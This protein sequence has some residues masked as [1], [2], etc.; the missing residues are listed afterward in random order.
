VNPV[1][2]SSGALAA[3]SRRRSG[4]NPALRGGAPY[5]AEPGNILKSNPAI[6]GTEE[7]RPIIVSLGEK[8]PRLQ[9]KTLVCTLCAGFLDFPS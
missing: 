9:A 7:Q 4:L 3:L 8:N 6:S 2:N 1:R 5:G